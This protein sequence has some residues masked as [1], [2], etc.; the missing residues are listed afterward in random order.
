MTKLERGEGGREGRGGSR[1]REGGKRREQEE[2]ER[3]EEGAGS[4][5]SLR[6]VWS[7]SSRAA[8]PPSILLSTSNTRLMFSV[9]RHDS[10]SFMA[11]VHQYTIHTVYSMRY[12]NVANA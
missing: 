11:C 2:R 6:R 5:P 7:L 8:H 3:E 1:R 12:S 4:K 10:S 9:W